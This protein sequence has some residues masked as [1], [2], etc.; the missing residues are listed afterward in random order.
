VHALFDHVHAVP[1]L[2]VVYCFTSYTFAIQQS[3]V[4]ASEQQLYGHAKPISKASKKY[5]SRHV[6]KHDI[7]VYFTLEPD[8]RDRC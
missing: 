2:L 4:T 1:R 8:K 3:P 7:S 6:A 5:L